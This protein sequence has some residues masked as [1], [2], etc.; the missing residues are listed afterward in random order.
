MPRDASSGLVGEVSSTLLLSRGVGG[1]LCCWWRGF[2]ASLLRA[3][4]RSGT[5]LPGEKR[6]WLQGWAQCLGTS[7]EVQSRGWRQFHDVAFGGRALQVIAQAPL[8]AVSNRDPKGHSTVAMESTLTVGEHLSNLSLCDRSPDRY[9]LCSRRCVDRGNR[10]PPVSVEN[11]SCEWIFSGHGCSFSPG[12]SAP[13]GGGEM[14]GCWRVRRCS[15]NVGG[16]DCL[17]RPG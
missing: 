12:A 3:V 6:G 16:N 17:L 8:N 10:L 14:G 15:E 4:K 2:A 7:V 5:A 13:V 9:A 11:G 1:P